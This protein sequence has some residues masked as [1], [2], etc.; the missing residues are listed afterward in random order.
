MPDFSN[1]TR[2]F[3]ESRA[4]RAAQSI[5]QTW[6]RHPQWSL[7]A[8][9]ALAAS[10]AWFIATLLP[11]PL[12]D[13]AY[14][15]PLGA[16]VATGRTVMRSARS[17]AQAA[18]AV[19]VGAVIARLT[20]LL[21]LPSF[22]AI[23]IVV[24]IAILVAGWRGF[25]PLGDWVVTSALIVLIIG[26]S[27]SLGFVGAYAGLVAL[28]AVIGAAV[29]VALPPLLLIPSAIELDRLRDQLAEQLDTLADGLHGEEPPSPQEWDER[30]REIQPM[31]ARATAAVEESQES[32]R[33]NVRARRR[34][35]EVTLLLARAETLRITAETVED[36]S[37]L[38]MRW[39]RDDEHEVAF[40]PRIRPVVAEALDTYARVLQ[41]SQDEKSSAEV[42]RAAANLREVVRTERQ[43]G[44][45]DFFVAG[46][47][48]LALERGAGALRLREA[49]GEAGEKP[50]SRV[51]LGKLHMNPVISH[52]K[53]DV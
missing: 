40:G 44:G 35:G 25:G 22:I 1:A 37:R 26:S 6:A 18:G 32:A 2:R 16:V 12:S 34:S 43:T 27:D 20:D 5:D 42:D 28:G 48:V 17:G 21:G 50:I 11:S 23:A 51:S 39:E 10:L 7:A 45:E 13:Y 14:Y 3:R 46:T 41:E 47:V 4:V 8:K 19:V 49:E 33:A 52:R 15:A 31:V 38:V 29:N 36:I 53:R 9:G 30:R 24:A